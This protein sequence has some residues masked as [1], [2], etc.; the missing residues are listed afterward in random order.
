[1][2]SQEKVSLIIQYSLLVAG[3]EEDYRD[4]DLR[5]IHLIKYVYLADLEFAKNH[6]GETYTGINWQFYNFGP[7]ANEAYLQ[8]E[9]AALA[10]HA[11]KKTFPSDFQ[12]Q[13]EWCCYSLDVEDDD[14]LLREID[15]KLPVTITSALQRHIHSN[16]NSTADLLR[17]VYNTQPMRNA[18]PL[19][20]LDFS[21]VAQVAIEKDEEHTPYL[22][23]LTKKKQLDKKRR[24]KE[25]KAQIAGRKQENKSW[26][27]NLVKPPHEPRY[28]EVFEE[29]VRWLDSLA[30]EPFQEEQIEV[31]FD[32]AI[33]QS[34]TRRMD[35]SI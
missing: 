24:L 32:K 5:P 30:G 31:V 29:G 23:T 8:I 35:G 18:A 16:T 3:Q 21:C 2:N 15:M 7:Y 27:E 13:Q 28:D 11:I 33:W 25:L 1:M 22:Q 26:Q 19:E 4:R 20:Y 6:D 12:E 34:P 10:I 14:T 17:Y 9:P